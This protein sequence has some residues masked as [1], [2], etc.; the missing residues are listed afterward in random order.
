MYWNSIPCISERSF[1]LY[2]SSMS[3]IGIQSASSPCIKGQFSF[4]Q[5]A[6]FCIMVISILL[7]DIC[8]LGQTFSVFDMGL[9]SSRTRFS[10]SWWSRRYRKW[11]IWTL[12]WCSWRESRTAW[13]RCLRPSKPSRRTGIIPT[14]RWFVIAFWCICDVMR[15][16][17][18][19]H[20]WRHESDCLFET[21]WN[22][23]S[24]Y[25]FHVRRLENDF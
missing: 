23:F 7:G 4:L 1:T 5:N 22:W 18:L 9:P 15:V 21:T 8:L 25:S 10:A 11:W 17:V 19:V 3:C 24:L 16:I 2:W 12:R 14:W 13:G 6:F 20:V